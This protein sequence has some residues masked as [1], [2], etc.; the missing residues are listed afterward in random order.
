MT[1]FSW[2]PSPSLARLANGTGFPTRGATL[3]WSNGVG[4]G[5][6][7]NSA[8]PAAK[9]KTEARSR[10]GSEPRQG[11][12]RYFPFPREPL[13]NWKKSH[14]NFFRFH[15]GVTAPEKT[16]GKVSPG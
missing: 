10:N 9:K 15:K 3:A 2:S 6:F 1:D 7:G 11:R 13:Y 4:A 12:E 8:P 16:S 14:I 5:F